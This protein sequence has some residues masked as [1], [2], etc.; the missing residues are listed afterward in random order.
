M[1]VVRSKSPNI[2]TPTNMSSKPGNQRDSIANVFHQRIKVLY[3]KAAYPPTGNWAWITLKWIADIWWYVGTFIDRSGGPIL[4]LSCLGLQYAIFVRFDVGNRPSP[5]SKWP[6]NILRVQ[7]LQ[8]P[9]CFFQP[10]TS[11]EHL[12]N[13]IRIKH[14]IKMD[15]RGSSGQSQDAN[16]KMCMSHYVHF[17]NA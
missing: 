1:Q 14:G 17:F 12:Y 15:L 9:T 7:L 16:G 4:L 10:S 6:F 3:T 5:Q 11:G 13:S 2:Q 8:L